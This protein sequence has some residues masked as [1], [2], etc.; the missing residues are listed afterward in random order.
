V[1]SESSHPAAAST[2]SWFVALTALQLPG[3]WLLVCE[4]DITSD[5]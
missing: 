3:C 4:N 1:T 5:N 2:T